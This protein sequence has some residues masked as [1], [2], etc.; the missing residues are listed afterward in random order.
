MSSYSV[1]PRFI[2]EPSDTERIL[3]YYPEI[4]EDD[5]R[6]RW[7]S[8]HL[9]PYPKWRQEE[10]KMMNQPP[11]DVDIDDWVTMCPCQKLAHRPVAL[12]QL[13]NAAKES[14]RLCRVIAQA[15][16]ALIDGR[17]PRLYS[18]PGSESERAE[19]LRSVVVQ[20]RRGSESAV[21]AGYCLRICMGLAGHDI[22]LFRDHHHPTAFT[23]K[24]YTFPAA[25]VLASRTDS[26]RALQQ[27]EGWLDQCLSNHECFWEGASH[28]PKR[29]LDL[30]NHRTR[31]IETVGHETPY[32]CL[33]HRWG[34]DQHRRLISTVTT[35]QDHMDGIP[36]SDIPRTFQD[37]IKICRRLSIRYL[38]IDTLCI[39]QKR[40]GLTDAQVAETEADFATENAAMASI[41]RGSYFTIS[42][43]V[44]TN[45][46][47]GIF[48]SATI[49]HPISTQDDTGQPATIYASSVEIRHSSQP[50]DLET[51][52]WTFQ[53]SILPPRILTFDSHDITWRCRV[54]HLCQC[55][56]FAPDAPGW[57]D[58]WRGDLFATTSLLGKLDYWSADEIHGWWLSVV[59][60]YAN[61]RLTKPQDRF[62]ALSGLAQIYQGITGH[63]YNAGLWMETMFFDLCWFNENKDV[64]NG[65]LLSSHRSTESL[66]PT[67]SWASIDRPYGVSCFFWSAHGTNAGMKPFGHQRPVCTLIEKSCEPKTI[68]PTG[69]VEPGSYIELEVKLLSAV[70]IPYTYQ[71][72]KGSIPWGIGPVGNNFKVQSCLLDCLPEYD[73]V[74][75]GDEVFCAPILEALSHLISERACLILKHI[76]GRQYRR[77]GFCVLENLP[78]GM[79]SL[80]DEQLEELCETDEW[81]D[82]TGSEHAEF[83][84]SYA[85]QV[86]PDECE[87]I[88]LV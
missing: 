31:V 5:Y 20:Q 47:S 68:D 84:Q 46:D 71:Y 30:E 12:F 24:G 55:G 36:W 33:S 85:F 38:W 45:M 77:V 60:F 43:N 25:A 34:D 1:V 72:Q 66:A 64:V 83:V 54:D 50:T 9:Q 17:L 57:T 22:R 26:P 58:N 4:A 3:Q 74:S 13:C 44:S 27:A 23:I 42:A 56:Y 19:L 8:F 67:W 52:G 82:M 87:R 80:S 35:I 53:E 88:S 59:H 76:R 15:V 63:A 70:I 2:L 10:L 29:L 32:V 49:C 18:G 51:R 75:E 16:T 86:D 21:Y 62:P 41:Y 79:E 65:P 48:S 6:Y 40:G 28:P 61:R 73:N 37:A 7:S 78:A 81:L 39:L 11:Q 14:C 69:E